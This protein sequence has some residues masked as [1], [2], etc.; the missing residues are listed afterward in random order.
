[1]VVIANAR[2]VTKPLKGLVLERYRGVSREQQAERGDEH[3]TEGESFTHGE[4]ILRHYAAR[5][6]SVARKR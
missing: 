2:L 6:G 1:M 3:H 4:L 5:E